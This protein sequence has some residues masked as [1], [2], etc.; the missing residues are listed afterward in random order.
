MRTLRRATCRA[1]AITSRPRRS[2]A[3]C[4]RARTR[5]SARP[6]ASTPS[7][8]RARPSPRRGTRTAGP[9]SIGSGPAPATRPTGRFPQGARAQRAVHRGPAL[10]QPPALGSPARPRPADRLRRR[11]GHAGRQRRPDDRR[12]RVGPP[13]CGQPV[14][15][16]PGDLRRRRR[17]ADRA[18]GGG[19]AAG[20]RA[21]RDRRC[22]R[23]DR[24]RPA[25]RALPGRAPR[26]RGA[27]LCLRELRRAVPP[28][29]AR[30][31]RLQRPG[32]QPRFPHARRPPSRTWSARPR[33]CRSSQGSCGPPRSTI[34]R[35]T[36]SPGTATTRPTSTTS[37]A[38]T[39]SA[40]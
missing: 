24:G 6:S 12:G 39:R 19:A 8:C 10:A 28:A 18:A 26:G 17:A 1:S 4:R 3:P 36:W 23:R 15:G 33:W 40:R 35:S 14:D 32:Q 25:R 34:R 21:G 11:P 29:R 27:R 22:A 5:P 37:P 2:R 20:H 16:G 7:S 30:A 38:S 13:L 31:D 9:G